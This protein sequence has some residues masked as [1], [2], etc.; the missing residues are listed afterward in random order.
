MTTAL[1]F[2]VANVIVDWDPTRALAGQVSDERIQQFFDSEV[3]W[4]L[5]ARCDAGMP[6]ADALVE[7]DD[8]AP[9]LVDLYRLYIERFPLTVS[10]PIPGTAEVIRD[11]LAAGVPCNGLSNW[12]KENFN[13][14]R[15]AN[16]VIDELADVIVSGEVGL[17]KPDPAIFRYAL[18]RF[19]LPADST[20]M[21]DDTQVNLDS[22]AEVGLVTVLFTTAEQLRADLAGLGLL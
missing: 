11:L 9:H 17:A 19:D 5:N 1:I 8:Q 10:G 22:A 14:A 20:V 2:D 18:E 15:R 4:Q 7:M 12:A 16:P 6:I 3:F 21:I 13:V